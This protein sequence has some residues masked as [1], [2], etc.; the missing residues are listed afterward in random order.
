MKERVQR[1]EGQI[2][3]LSITV[4]PRSKFINIIHK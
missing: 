1:D 4:L 3:W 2:Q